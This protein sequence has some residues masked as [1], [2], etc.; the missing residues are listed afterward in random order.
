MQSLEFRAMNTSVLLAAEGHDWAMAGLNAARRFI[1]DCEQRFSRFLP[2][3]ELSRLNRFSGTWV[4]VSD[5]LMDLLTQ[6]LDF[7][8]ETNG[9]FDPSILTDLKRAGYDKCM[10]EIRAH[11]VSS[12]FASN[13]TP[14]PAFDKISL[15]PVGRRV[16]LP[17]GMEIDLG[18]IAKGWI[19]EKA[20]AVLSS[21]SAICAVS[22]GGD[23]SFI[24]EPS[25]G[26]RW[27]VEVEDPRKP[28]ETV[29][30]LHVRQGAVVT[31]SSTKRAWSQNGRPR[32]HLIDPRTG[33]PAE[34]DWLSVTVIA[35]Q[36]TL[37]EVYAKAL[38]IGG[39]G[40]A[41]RLCSQRPDVA[42]IAINEMGELFC[43]QN[44]KEYLDALDYIRF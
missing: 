44:S 39:A 34:S 38:L 17:H 32:H 15:D 23:I 5:D 40:E 18:G 14:R 26:S 3:S 30:V 31:S 37:A 24:G 4:T 29:A 11:G 10:D 20:A 36:M 28:D 41:E 16:R 22:A 7:Y 25:D 6:S 9:L 42:F 8:D 35:P 1:E 33:E 2:E 27:R 13:Q 21:Y 19:V 12:L 43:P